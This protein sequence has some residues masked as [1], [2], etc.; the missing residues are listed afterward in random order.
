MYEEPL[1]SHPNQKTIPKAVAVRDSVD[2]RSKQIMIPKG[3]E[4]QIE[5]ILA[6]ASVCKIAYHGQ[7]GL[8]KL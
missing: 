3:T 1:T 8:F 2:L 4:V 6:Q 7:I 5:E